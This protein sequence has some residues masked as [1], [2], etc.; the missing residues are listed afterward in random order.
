MALSTTPAK[1]P[2]KD[3]NLSGQDVKLTALIPDHAESLFPNISGSQNDRL[4]IY[5]PYGPYSTLQTFQSDIATKSLSQDPVFYAILS[6]TNSQPIGH[7]ALMRIDTRNRV[8]EIGHVLYSPSLQRT[9]AATEVQYLLLK[10]C[11]EELG[12]RR[13]E[14]K[15]DARNEPSKKAALRLGFKYEGT[16]RQHMIIKGENRDTAWF[17]IL[18]GEWDVVKGA[19]QEWLQLGNFDKEGK[20]RRALEAIRQ[21]PLGSAS[22]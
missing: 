21:G 19:L 2:S 3:V 6:K 5:M 9:R 13:V 4:W 11:F 7:A 15:C 8:I 20:Q 14:W 1:H 16:F 18:D 22:V 12:Y 17:A 10:Y